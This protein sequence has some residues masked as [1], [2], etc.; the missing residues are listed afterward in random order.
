MPFSENLSI[1]LPGRLA[2]HYSNFRL[3]ERVLLTGHSH[4]A[5]PDVAWEGVLQCWADA[6][7]GVDDKWSAAFDTA[8]RVRR[9]FRGWL[10]GAD[11][12]IALAQNTHELVYRF[13]S[14]LDF[15]ARPRVVMTDGEFHSI[16][17][18]MRRL[19][20]EGVEVVRVSS[21]ELEALPEALI[22][23]V[24][25]K[26]ACVLVSAV[27]FQSS[28]IAHGL[29]SVLSHANGEGVPMLVDCYHALGPVPFSLYDWGLE[30]AYVV[31][32]GYKYLQLGEG[33]C[34]L[35]TPTNCELRPV[36]TG[37][38]ADFE[39]L[40]NPSTGGLVG[41]ARGDMR[42]AGATYDPTSHYRAAR[43]MDFFDE[44]G[45]TPKVLREVSQHQLRV[46]ADAFDRLDI[47]AAEICRDRSV[48]LEELGGFLT[49]KS[50]R[51]ADLVIAMRGQGVFVDARG[52]H[53]R[54]GPAPYLSDDRLKLGVSAL[55]EALAG[56]SSRSL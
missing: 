28:R 12:A 56:L 15:G 1:D 42:F 9:G 35:R 17:R 21:T 29:S 45:L 8:E 26:T 25:S 2:P 13:L 43:V 49:L 34:F 22:A 51:A 53:L 48:G 16:S 20:E 23:A 54:L 19:E 50:P 36:N 46:L 11:G 55:A 31:G 27:F 3:D 44:Q 30:N 33:N 41:Y 39:N 38:F 6:S 18:Q 10:G 32:G 7:M 40:D 47:D 52:E 24:D 4:Q 14:A 5:W 37:W